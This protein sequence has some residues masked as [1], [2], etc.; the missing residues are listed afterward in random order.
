M[1]D[2]H[3]LYRAWRNPAVRALLDTVLL[4]GVFRTRP[5]LGQSLL[6]R[7]DD[8]SRDPV[9]DPYPLLYEHLHG[10]A[11]AGFA[12]TFEGD[13]DSRITRRVGQIRALV[14]A[15]PA[16]QSLVDVGC[17]D[18][19]VTAGLARAWSIPASR[20][21]AVDVFDRVADR[22]TVTYKPLSDGRIACDDSSTDL[23]L[24]LMV[25]HH[26]TDPACLLREVFRIVR[27]GGTLIVRESDVDTPDLKLFNFVMEDFYYQVFRRLPGVPNPARHESA[28]HWLTLLRKT[29]F[30]VERVERPEPGNPFTPV[31][32]VVRRPG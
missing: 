31:F 25:L 8:W 3:P 2:D 20:A 11:N 23:A 19:R 32:L 14:A 16:P 5:D 13:E 17:G 12:P 28:A 29:G 18:A 24:L 26:E 15:R 6:V 1:P 30:A 22:S 21:I 27:P 7:I 4:N 10:R 9:S